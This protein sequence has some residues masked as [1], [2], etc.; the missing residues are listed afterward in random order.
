MIGRPILNAKPLGM[1]VCR[2]KGMSRDLIGKARAAEGPVS[3][4]SAAG[5]MQ[6]GVCRQAEEAV[7]FAP[8]Y[9][10]APTVRAVGPASPIA[11][12]ISAVSSI[13]KPSVVARFRASESP[14][15]TA[16][17]EA[18]TTI[19]GKSVASPLEPAGAIA[20]VSTPKAT[21]P[22]ATTVESSETAAAVAAKSTSPISTKPAATAVAPETAEASSKRDIA[23]SA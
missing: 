13:P 2:G 10:P 12:V 5:R 7:Q 4:P 21:T 8:V 14:A 3:G 19:P 15:V 1:G 9:R 6:A 23:Q 11:T 22:K 17:V 20:E 18:P 16:V